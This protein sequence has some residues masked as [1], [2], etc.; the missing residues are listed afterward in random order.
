MTDR[1]DTEEPVPASPASSALGEKHGPALT[2]L[3]TLL[4][5]HWAHWAKV[6]EPCASPV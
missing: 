3:L 5:E 6:K 1:L 2:L 4:G